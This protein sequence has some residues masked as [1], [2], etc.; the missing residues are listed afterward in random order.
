VFVAAIVLHAVA[1]WLRG[2]Y[3]RFIWLSACAVIVF[4]AELAILLGL[5]ALQSLVQCR[6]TVGNVLKNA[7]P[8][9]LVWLG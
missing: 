5:F 2:H 1:D 7:V 4:R 3:G 8:S 9:S 6:L